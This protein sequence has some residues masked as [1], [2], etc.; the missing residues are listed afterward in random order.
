MFYLLLFFFACGVGALVFPKNSFVYKYS[1]NSLIAIDNA[2]NA[3]VLL[4]DPDETI[5]SR[6]YKGSLRGHKGWSLLNDLLDKV[7]PGHGKRVVE[8]DEGTKS[9]KSKLLSDD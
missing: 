3:I 8:W 6:A 4:G 7:D 9:G 1:M 5:S 2:V